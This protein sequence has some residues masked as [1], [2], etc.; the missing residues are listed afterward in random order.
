MALERA[1]FS[2]KKTLQIGR[3]IREIGKQ[4]LLLPPV[5]RIA[6]NDVR[7]REPVLDEVAGLSQQLIKYSRGA[8]IHHRV[9][10]DDG[11]HVLCY[12]QHEI[13][14]IDLRAVDVRLQLG[15]RETDP[16]I[17]QVPGPCSRLGDEL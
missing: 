8:L 4:A 16:L 9:L 15:E 7:G 6:D 10:R 5:D 14:R 12:W 17:M 11:R 3:E 2:C 13:R 1:V